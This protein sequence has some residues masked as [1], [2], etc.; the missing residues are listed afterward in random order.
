MESKA[1]RDLAERLA[2][3]VLSQDPGAPAATSPL[4]SEQRREV[5]F[6]AGIRPEPA[7]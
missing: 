2:G 4:T 7:V 1:A 6:V 5:A 3:T